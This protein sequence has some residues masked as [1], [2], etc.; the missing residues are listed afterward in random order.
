MARKIEHK[1]TLAGEKY[2]LSYIDKPILFKNGVKQLTLPVLKQYILEASLPI[3]LKNSTGNDKNTYTIASDVLW[4]FTPATQKATIKSIL[5]KEATKK[6]VANVQSQ[7]KTVT[8]KLELSANFKV[9]MIC[10]REKQ[11]HSSLIHPATNEQITFVAQPNGVNTFFPH[12]N[13]PGIDMTWRDYVTNNQYHN[14]IPFMVYQLYSHTVYRNLFNSFGERL[15][16]L[17]AGWGLVKAKFRLPYY[18][19]TF[20]AKAQPEN[21]RRFNNPNPAYDDF[22]ALS[23][24]L[25]KGEDIVFIGGKDYI[26]QFIAL[27][28]E[29]EGNKII[30]YKGCEPAI[31]LPDATYK[32]RRYGLIKQNTNW[33]YDLA[34]KFAYGLIP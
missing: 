32:F 16:I 6:K 28:I 29:L 27:T 3:D 30:Y 2:H 11:D 26:K 13:I 31:R 24:H 23:N 4:H 5:K 22:K 33:H 14:V 15:F 9:V 21:R 20:S 18:N 1:F 12:R 34:Q 8:G 25:N 19:I 7:N 10:A 17:S